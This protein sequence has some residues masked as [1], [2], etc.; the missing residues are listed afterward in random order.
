VQEGA[1]GQG[2]APTSSRSSLDSASTGGSQAEGLGL[3]RVVH[4]PGGCM[5]GA[6]EELAAALTTAN[7]MEQLNHYTSWAN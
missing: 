6:G 7:V 5:L 4:G 3:G 2:G 1:P